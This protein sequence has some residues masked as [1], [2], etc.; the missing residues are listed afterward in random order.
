MDEKRQSFPW[1]RTLI[2]YFENLNE[3][4]NEIETI[5]LTLCENPQFSPT[6]L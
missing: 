6:R 3:I 5:R 1:L 4:D 2:N